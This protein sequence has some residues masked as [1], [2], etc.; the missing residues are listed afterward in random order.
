MSPGRGSFSS[1]GSTTWEIKMTRLFSAV[2]VTVFLLG[3]GGSAGAE[4]DKDAL[5]ILDKAI[6]ALGGEDK[7][8]MAKAFTLKAKGT[9]TFADNDNP[10]TSQTTVQGLE[11]VRR[12]FEGEFGGNKIRGVTVVNGDKGWRQFG[13]DKM[14]LDEES[15]ANEKRTLY[16]QVIPISLL[17]LRGKGFKA[18]TAGEE[19]VGDK[20]ALAVKVTGPDGKDFQLY[21]DKASGL[22]VKQVAK[23]IGFMKDEYTQETTFGNYKVI[24][25]IKR[26]TK[27]VSKRDG[28]KFIDQEITDFKILTKVD[29]KTFALTD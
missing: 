21:F 29:P 6:N 24:D 7:L 17:P 3:L 12:E 18:V 19:K 20:A 28:E 15:I 10:F 25:G 23:V 13:D 14:D 5:A 8:K 2:G 22:P 27:I 26:A 16:L 9:I 4:G 11:R 1:L